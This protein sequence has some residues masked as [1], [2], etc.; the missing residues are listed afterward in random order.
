MRRGGILDRAGRVCLLR[1]TR[2]GGLRGSGWRQSHEHE[3]L[4]ETS[5]VCGTT[6]TSVSETGRGLRGVQ[7]VVLDLDGTVCEGGTAIAGAADVIDALRSEGLKVCFATNTTRHPRTT[8][9]EQ[10]HRLGIDASADDVMT[11]PTAAVT[12]LRQHGVSSVALHLPEATTVEFQEFMLDAPS[13]EA[14]V[15]G[16]L[17]EG[18]TF[19]RLNLAF[20][21]LLAGAELVA[22]Q[23]NRYWKTA[24]G[25]RLD[26]GPFVAALEY[27]S[28]KE[29]VTA[30]KPSVA[31]FD[32]AARSLDLPKSTL[33]M[34]GDDVVSDVGGAAL[35]GL[36]G[37]LVRTGKFRP[38]DL[39]R[40]IKA[41][42]VI[43]SIADLPR[44][45]TSSS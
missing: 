7:G 28:G 9:V 26:A 41:N 13:P 44:A 2:E 35:A 18:W 36:R 22:I 25:L 40:G 32:A 5:N 34:V 12:W 38:D 4:V 10:L 3:H 27:A 45:L 6:V 29:A 23:R 16:D 14:V 31:F 39:E 15:V 1:A 24:D 37:I 21:Q 19:E 17:G 11:A 43:D 20:R 8:L 30:G 33:V 42:A